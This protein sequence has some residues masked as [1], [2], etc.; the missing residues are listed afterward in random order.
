MHIF[1]LFFFIL[2]SLVQDESTNQQTENDCLCLAAEFCTK[3]NEDEELSDS[4]CCPIKMS[5]ICSF[6][7]QLQS[8]T[9]GGYDFFSKITP[10]N[11]GTVSGAYERVA[12][13][14]S[15]NPLI[16]CPQH[17]GCPTAFNRNRFRPYG[18]RLFGY[19]HVV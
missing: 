15:L 14:S 17:Q 19:S 13:G 10:R 16:P 1:E 9:P 8:H 11:P 18:T 3:E 4:L 12:T 7:E 5:P 2:F 6:A